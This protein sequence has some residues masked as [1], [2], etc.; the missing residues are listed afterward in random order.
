MTIKQITL[1]AA[2]VLAAAFLPVVHAT[3]TEPAV[4][5]AFDSMSASNGALDGTQLGLT[6]NAPDA[7]WT[8]GRLWNWSQP[9]VGYDWGR[10]YNVA[11]LG[12]E[13]SCAALPLASTND[14]VRPATLTVTCTFWEPSHNGAG[15]GFWADEPGMENWP[16]NDNV[17]AALIYAPGSGTLRVQNGPSTTESTVSVVPANDNVRGE[18]TL[19]FTIDTETGSLSYVEWNG[20]PVSDLSGTAFTAANTLW[21]GPMSWSGGRCCFSSF[22]VTEG[23]EVAHLAAVTIEAA[24]VF[25]LVGDTISFAVSAADIVSGDPV[26]VTASCDGAS[27]YS[28]SEGALSW[29]P[30]AAGDYEFSFSA[31]TAAGTTTRTATFHVFDAPDEDAPLTGIYATDLSTVTKGG[32]FAGNPWLSTTN[33]TSAGLVVNAPGGKWLWATGFNW[34]PPSIDTWN[35]EYNWGDEC[36][37]VMLPLAST[38]DYAKPAKL[39]LECS[40]RVTGKSLFGYWSRPADVAGGDSAMGA[41]LRFSGLM[42]DPLTGAQSVQLYSNGAAVGSPSPIPFDTGL[43]QHTLKFVVNTRSGLLSNPTID[44]FPIGGIPAEAVFTDEA[45]TY[46]G[47][48]TLNN[49]ASGHSGLWVK[50]FRVDGVGSPGTMFLLR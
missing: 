2:V 11:S 22:T 25:A 5:Y 39:R 4:I 36:S 23:E 41:T 1:N 3:A 8:C 38:N 7:V 46:V 32:S 31:T 27:G 21:V 37:S 49:S 10:N 6:T 14:Y 20:A 45:T 26:P 19:K 35:N 47:A 29:T 13:R 24:N 28:I 50:S 30:A 15:V 17:A 48:A 18:Q 12:E 40:F 9:E 42:L 44:G 43:S 34:A 33:N 16:A